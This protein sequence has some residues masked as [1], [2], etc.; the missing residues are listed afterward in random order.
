MKKPFCVFLV[1][2]ASSLFLMG[3]S[4]S[5]DSVKEIQG[6][7][8]VDY[9]ASEGYPSV[10]KAFNNFFSQPKWLIQKSQGGAPIAV[11]TG[12]AQF[13]KQNAK[14][15]IGFLKENG[16]V[17][18][19]QVFINNKLVFS[20]AVELLPSMATLYGNNVIDDDDLLAAVYLN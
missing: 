3:S 1:V 19:N 14:Y 12:I 6:G 16:Y 8:F 13:N 4:A 9:P 7:H 20:R 11:F 17:Y 5:A 2:F 15:K 18:L 10:G